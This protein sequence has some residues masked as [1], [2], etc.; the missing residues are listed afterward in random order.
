MKRFILIISILF[1]FHCAFAEFPVVKQGDVVPNDKRLGKPIGESKQGELTIASFNVRNLGSRSRSIKDFEALADLVDEAD[2]V[3]FQ[4]VGLGMFKEEGTKV[5]EGAGKR[6]AAIAALFQIYL[7]GDWEIVLA[8]HPS[9]KKA[10]RE[11]AILAHRK[12]AKGYDIVTKWQGYETISDGKRNMPVFKLI[13]SKSG[14]TKDLYL[15]SV[16]LTPDDPHRGSQMIRV[17]D[18]LVKHNDKMAIVMGD[19]N[20]GYKKNSKIPAEENYKGEDKVLQLQ[21]EGKIFQLFA[22]LSYK[23]AGNENNL[24]TNMGFRKSAFFYDQFLLTPKLAG[25]LADGGR[26]LEDCGII[27]FGVHG[28][29]MK[30]AIA[31]SEKNRKYGFDKYFKY[32]NAGGMTEDTFN[33]TQKKAREKASSDV[34]SQAGNGATWVLSDHRV[35]WMQL[36]IW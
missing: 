21:K 4:E 13:L 5:S 23:G 17:A 29:Y 11:T 36:K 8:P 2:V 27:A 33:E 18:W 14:Q 16:H 7:G 3:L 34:S 24:R 12:K 28:K 20:W 31:K 26:L 30:K 32:L 10:G 1:L 25:M 35:V 15:G 22:S 6:L 19:F 9:G